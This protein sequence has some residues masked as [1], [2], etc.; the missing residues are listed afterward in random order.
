MLNSLV[1]SF[2]DQRRV[3]P[4]FGLYAACQVYGLAENLVMETAF[5][6]YPGK[7]RP[8]MDA[9]AYFDG[10]TV[11][12]HGRP[13]SLQYGERKIGR[14]FGMMIQD[15]RRAADGKIAV[16]CRLDLLYAKPR[17]RV[18][19]F[20]EEIIQKQHS[21]LGPKALGKW[22]KG[23]DI[24]KD[25]RRIGELICDRVFAGAQPRHY[26][27][28]KHV[29]EQALRLS[30]LLF[31][32]GAR[33]ALTQAH[34]IGRRPDEH[35]IR[36]YGGDAYCCRNRLAIQVDIQAENRQS[37]QS[38]GDEKAEGH[39]QETRPAEQQAINEAHQANGGH[40]P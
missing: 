19:E 8:G 40:W 3:R 1:C 11:S 4:R 6:Y 17:R 7:H 37:G 24:D 20:S 14:C 9:G 10:W 15:L 28:W 2:R 33:R 5:P 12:Y 39:G 34:P 30:L 23:D 25:H 31:Q 27:A 35:D 21:S 18:V 38:A 32:C 36:K 13:G 16:A 29:S 26:A 22:S